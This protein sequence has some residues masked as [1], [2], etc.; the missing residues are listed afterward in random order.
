MAIEFGPNTKLGDNA[1][2]VVLKDGRRLGGIYYPPDGIYRFHLG[3][4]EKL[5]PAEFFD[6]DVEILKAKIRVR[7]GG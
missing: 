1:H 4:Q 6:P 3:D 2:T 5:G 7:Y